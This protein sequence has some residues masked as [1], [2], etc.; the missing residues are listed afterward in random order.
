M[1]HLSNKVVLVVAAIANRRDAFG[2]TGARTEA[3]L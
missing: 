2:F 1:Q 3:V